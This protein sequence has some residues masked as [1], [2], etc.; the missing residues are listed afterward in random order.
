MEFL[1]IIIVF[2]KYILIKLKWIME[3]MTMT[4]DDDDDDDDAS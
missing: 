1:A 2:S 3:L 4:E